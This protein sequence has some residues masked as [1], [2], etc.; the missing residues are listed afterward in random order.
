MI[1]SI[2]WSTLVIILATLPRE[3]FSQVWLPDREQREG[4]GIKVGEKLVFHPGAV[5]EGGY[6]TN[7]VRRSEPEGAGRL[8]LSS[9]LDLAT[10]THRRLETSAVAPT[11]PKLN[12]RFG[13]AGYYDFF[14]SD[15]RSIDNQDDTGIDTH[16]A[17]IF[18]PL[19]NYTLNLH[20]QF[21][22]TPDMYE[23]PQEHHARNH[24]R[25]R[26]GLRIRP[27]GGT[28]SLS[29]SCGTDVLIYDEDIVG[30]RNN[31][32]VFD[33]KIETEWRM[34]PKTSLVS[35][36]LFTPTNYLSAYHI[37]NDSRPVRVYLGVRGLL[38]PKFGLS[39]FVGYGTSFYKKG[40]NFEHVLANGEL[41]FFIT[42]LAKLRIGG[43]RD[44][45]DSFYSNYYV[46]N[47]GYL[48]YD[49]LFAQ[50]FLVSLKG[51]VFQ[52]K[53]SFLS[54]QYGTTVPNTD[55]RKDLWTGVTLLLELRATS[56][57]SVMSSVVYQGN[58]SNFAYSS[59][60]E[61]QS[62]WVDFQ[63]VEVLG[64]VRVHY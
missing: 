3:A 14:F 62:S 13:V 21:I 47:G 5:V 17:L 22:R 46:R 43:S 59:N 60:A 23:S 25:P 19:G 45:V 38:T 33:V 53:Y 39:A 44:F 58:I 54:G 1:K 55:Y 52:R 11:P 40:E 29:L 61:D 6:D 27:G 12:F 56:W 18:F 42:P 32:V 4:D 41:M 36:I 50:I 20:A 26:V 24:I 35:R 28:L 30:Y 31:R 57:L 7:P 15:D 37:N 16:L 9:Y 2:A 63:R 51:E 64:G 49:H 48:T 10:R 34:L 8:R